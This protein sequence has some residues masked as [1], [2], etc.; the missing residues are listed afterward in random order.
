MS[1]GISFD[2]GDTNCASGCRA[3]QKHSAQ[4]RYDPECHLDR[5]RHFHDNLCFVSQISTPLNVVRMK[6]ERVVDLE[7]KISAKAS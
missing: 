3:T 2:R 5:H 6:K 1:F 7:N 4:E